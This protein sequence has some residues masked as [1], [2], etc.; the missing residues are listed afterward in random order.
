MKTTP[1]IRRLAT[2]GPVNYTANTQLRVLLRM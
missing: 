1:I 2:G